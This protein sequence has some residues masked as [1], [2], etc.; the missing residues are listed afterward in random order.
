[1]RSY[2]TPPSE[3][4]PLPLPDA[5]PI[6]LVGADEAQRGVPLVGAPQPQRGR[7]CRAYRDHAR[8]Q[9]LQPFPPGGVRP[10]AREQ[11]AAHAARLARLRST[12]VRIFLRS[13]IA[14][15]VTSTSSSSSMNSSACSSDSLIGGTRPSS[16]S[17]PEARKL[18]SCLPR[19]AL[20]VRSLSLALMPTSWPS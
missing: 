18:V 3:P 16:S 7:A 8:D 1:S 6:S 17:L 15:G 14:F 19:R 20:T 11:R 13:R 9:R 10:P 12:S 5:L 4:H 2:A